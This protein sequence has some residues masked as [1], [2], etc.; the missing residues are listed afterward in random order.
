VTR[1]LVT[2]ASGFIGRHLL[3]E[4]KDD[5]SIVAVARARPEP[6]GAPLHPHIEW[7]QADVSNRESALA[8]HER[9]RASG[10]VDVVVHLAG[11]Y[12]FTGQDAPE[13]RSTNVEGL[14]NL[15]DIS[16]RLQPRR[17]IFSSSVAA[18]DFSPPGRAIDESTPP[19]GR[20]PYARSKRRG[21][22]M[23]REFSRALP[24][25]IVRFAALFSDWGEY[26]PLYVFLSEWLSPGWRSRVLAG[27]G[28]SA[29]P[30]L[31]IQ[32]ATSFFGRLLARLDDLGPCE[33]LT[34]SNDGATS[35]LELYLAAT[36]CHFGQRR[37]PLLVPRSLCRVGL[38]GLDTLGVVTR[39]RPFERPWMG[40]CIDRALFV[41]ASRTRAR[42]GWAPKERLEILRRMP[43]LIHNRRT[44]PDEWVR[45]NHVSPRRVRL[46]TSTRIEAMLAARQDGICQRLEDVLRDPVR[47]HRFP[48]YLD[49]TQ[50]HLEE[51][52]RHL[53]EQLLCAIR[54]GD[55]GI[56]MSTCR[57][58]AERWREDGLPHE[59]LWGALE[60]LDYV[61]LEAV[62][63][64]PEA[65]GL[66]QALHDHI[67]MTVHFGVDMVHEVS[68]QRARARPAGR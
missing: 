3:R 66:E 53:V 46:R 12:D 11:Y 36:A 40:Q 64:L 14:R 16:R 32:D 26:E 15:L 29:I 24:C 28:R 13:Y 10:G 31:H 6:A 25:C 42:L 47:S 49:C 48:G 55:K 57:H 60:C 59:E 5:H 61:C 63:D 20:S 35:H 4:L 51:R 65:Q 18:C 8:L 62:R 45:R 23:V 17:F 1:F 50:E 39:R 52:H 44:R 56:F 27:R 34:A 54:T 21:E 7:L 19:E 67:S 22:E 2:G 41:D 58:L 38:R 33:T 30:Y 43:F 68:E 9:V 37:R